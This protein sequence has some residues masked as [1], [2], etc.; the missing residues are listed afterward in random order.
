[1]LLIVHIIF[2]IGSLA[3]MAG[4]TFGRWRNR[5][6]DYGRVVQAS[7]LSFCGLM[8]TGFTM[9]IVSHAN[10]LNVCTSGLAWLAGLAAMYAVYAK[11]APAEL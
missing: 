9:V 2:A 7:F 6:A 5:G 8:A 10:L 4:A 11:L 3:L 1:M